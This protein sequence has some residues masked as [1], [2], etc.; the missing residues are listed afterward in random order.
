MTRPRANETVSAVFKKQN[1]QTK[2]KHQTCM[3]W[4]KKLT[5]VEG[6]QNPFTKLELS[7]TQEFNVCT[8]VQELSLEE[9]NCRLS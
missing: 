4:E 9:T 1:K 6:T 7:N 2:T 5:Q 3:N 8:Y